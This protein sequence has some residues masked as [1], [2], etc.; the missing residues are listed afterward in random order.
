MVKVPT[1]KINNPIGLWFDGDLLPVQKKRPFLIISSMIYICNKVTPNH[2]I[3][4]KIIE[5]ID[6]NSDIP[7]YKIGFLNDWR[8]QPIWK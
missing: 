6:R 4:A 7:I 8:L 3:K 1:Y 5:L 2:Q